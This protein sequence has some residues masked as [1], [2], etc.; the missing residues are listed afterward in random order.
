MLLPLLARADE[1]AFDR[2]TVSMARGGARLLGQL[3]AVAAVAAV[4]DTSEAVPDMHGRSF[5]ARL[6]AAWGVAAPGGI[7]LLQS[8]LILCVD[9]ELN[10]STFTTRCVASAGSTL[11]ASVLAGLAA[12]QGP[13]HGGHTRRVEALLR[14]SESVGGVRTA[15]A[16]RLARGDSIP[17]FGQPLYPAGDPRTR[18]LLR[19][20][21]RLFPDAPENALGKELHSAGQK[22]LGQYPTVDVALVLIARVLGLPRDSALTIFALG[23][24]IGWIGHVIEQGQ[25][26]KLIRPRARYIGPRPT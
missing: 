23:R 20:L 10:V 8:A 14:E 11:Y 15:I 21:E 19:S 7:E 13:L 2:S 16:D 22:L 17:R 18:E 5:V 12:L 9:H 26:A 3:A 25:S 24:A 4:A 6:A 1:A